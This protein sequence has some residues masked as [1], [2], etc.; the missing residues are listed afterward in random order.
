[1]S[2]TRAI[3]TLALAAALFSSSGLFIKITTVSPLYLFGARSLVAALTLLVVVRRL[4]LPRTPHQ[5]GGMLA[6]A[7]TQLLFIF[8]TRQ[9]TAANA[10]FIQ[11]TA[12][13]YVAFIGIWYLQ[14][15][16]RQ[17]DWW[18]M[19]AILVG[20]LIFLY[21]D[22]SPAGLLG[23][24]NA[25]LS[26]ICLAWFVLFMRRAKDESTINIALWGNIVGAIITLPVLLTTPL[27][28]WDNIG[29]IAFLGIVQIG[30]GLILMSMAV[31]QLSAVETILIQ[32]LEPILNPIWVFMAIGERPTVWTLF[33]GVIVLAAVTWRSIIAARTEALA[34]R[35]AST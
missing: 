33:G 8:S 14:E 26:G 10:I 15:R 27:P 24:L 9:T 2:R 21:D 25:L 19:G 31:K 6:L 20:L 23:T 16:P 3:I 12:P 1:M 35:R 29:S 34:K 11:Y 17:S 5:I 18:A 30:L 32:S 22:L 4:E 7:L 13:I 28:S